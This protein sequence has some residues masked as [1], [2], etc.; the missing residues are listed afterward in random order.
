MMTN[1][2]WKNATLSLSALMLVMLVGCPQPPDSGSGGVSALPD[3]SSDAHG[4]DDLPSVISQLAEMNVT[5]VEAL[6][7]SDTYEDAHGSLHDVG[8]LLGHIPDLLEASDLPDDKKQIIKDSAAELF[9]GY[10]SFDEHLHGS[11]DDFDADALADTLN[12]AM[13]AL[14]DAVPSQ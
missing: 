3:Q 10:G 11:E 6:G 12:N 8:H 7:S 4:H 5:I 9:E 13:A 2:R 1:P 14:R